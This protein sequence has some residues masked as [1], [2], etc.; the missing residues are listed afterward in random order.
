[1]IPPKLDMQAQAIE[2]PQPF[3]GFH[4]FK[5]TGTEEYAG[6]VTRPRKPQLANL[7]DVPDSANSPGTIV[8]RGSEEI[9]G[10]KWA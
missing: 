6:E 5:G 7:L 2:G 9:R 4:L 8:K 3:P 10:G 1:V